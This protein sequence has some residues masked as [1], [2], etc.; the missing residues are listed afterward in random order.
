M[1]ELDAVENRRIHEWLAQTNQHHILRRVACLADHV[2]EDLVC[3]VGLGCLWVSR[4]HIGQYRL[5]LTVVST[6]YSMGSAGRVGR[7]ARYPHRSLA[8]FQTL[9]RTQ[10]TVGSIV[11]ARRPLAVRD[12]K[13]RRGK[14]RR[15]EKR[16]ASLPI[17]G[18]WES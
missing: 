1:T 4:G 5:H 14:G 3:H 6:M 8:R 9:M 12:M 15:V 18:V 11:A 10:S 2:L 7:R 17:T 13:S 16:P